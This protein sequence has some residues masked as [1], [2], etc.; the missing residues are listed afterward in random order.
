MVLDSSKTVYQFKRF[1][2]IDLILNIYKNHE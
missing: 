1:N 2:E